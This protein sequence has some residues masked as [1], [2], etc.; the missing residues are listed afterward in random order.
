MEIGWQ[1][2]RYELTETT[3]FFAPAGLIIF[4]LRRK[5]GTRTARWQRSVRDV[6]WIRQLDRLLNVCSR[7]KGFALDSLYAESWQIFSL[8]ASEARLS[9]RVGCKLGFEMSVTVERRWQIYC[10][11]VCLR[12]IEISIWCKMQRRLE[13]S[14]FRSATALK[15]SRDF[16]WI[17]KRW[18]VC[19]YV[20]KMYASVC[21]CSVVLEADGR[22]VVIG[23]P[24]FAGSSI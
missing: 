1:Q 2:C 18:G 4:G 19:S 11:A 5:L 16:C 3:L 7:L 6:C 10:S 20:C 22:I 15:R 13:A 23:P 8:Y 24:N 9:M 12:F 17:A 14:L 21:D